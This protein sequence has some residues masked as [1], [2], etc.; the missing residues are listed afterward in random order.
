MIINNYYYFYINY[1]LIGFIMN[2]NSNYSPINTLNQVQ[3]LLHKVERKNYSLKSIQQLENKLI[4]ESLITYLQEAMGGVVKE[5]GKEHYEKNRSFYEKYMDLV[6]QLD[7]TVQS[8]NETKYKEAES[9]YESGSE[10]EEELDSWDSSR[11]KQRIRG[12]CQAMS[13][14]LGFF[15]KEMKT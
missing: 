2:I 1:L 14:V 15:Q 10:E 6:V 3:S 5:L 8:I 11:D 13:E 4:E 12:V 9:D 7:K